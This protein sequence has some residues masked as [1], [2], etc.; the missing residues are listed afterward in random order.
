[1]SSPPNP[2][3]PSL[4]RLS[5]EISSF[6]DPNV[7]AALQSTPAAGNVDLT[8][9]APTAPPATLHARLIAMRAELAGAIS[10]RRKSDARCSAAEVA[11][12]EAQAAAAATDAA[13][14][15]ERVQASAA[16]DA[17]QDH[18]TRLE[19][20]RA[21]LA[22]DSAEKSALVAQLNSAAE[23][24]AEAR[25]PT[26]PGGEAVDGAAF[27]ARLERSNSKCAMLK[28]QLDSTVSRGEK[29]ADHFSA[30]IS[31][32]DE[33][34]ERLQHSL[35]TARRE[36]DSFSAQLATSGDEHGKKDVDLRRDLLSLKAELSSRVADLADTRR[37]RAAADSKVFDLERQARILRT[38][39]NDPRTGTDSSVSPDS[40]AMV[41]LREEAAQMAIWIKAISPSGKDL[42][43][44]I[45]ILK[46]VAAQPP[47]PAVGQGLRQEVDASRERSVAL[48]SSSLK[49]QHQVAEARSKQTIDALAKQLAAAVASSKRIAA[50]RTEFER[51]FS[52]SERLRQYLERKNKHLQLA[53]DEIEEG[54][55][56][57]DFG[58]VG[59][60]LKRV[61]VQLESAIMRESEYKKTM[62]LFEKQLTDQDA[63]IRGLSVELSVAS[64]TKRSSIEQDNSTAIS[65]LRAQLLSA[66]QKIAELEHSCL[67]LESE[68]N[69]ARSQNEEELDYNPE[70]V[71]VLHS[72]AS[73]PVSSHLNPVGGDGVD[74]AD[75]SAKRRRTY[76]SRSVATVDQSLVDEMRTKI[77]DLEQQNKE[78]EKLSKVG[79]R[80][81]EVAKRKIEEVRQACCS[82]FGWTMRINGT[83]YRLSSMYA[84]RQE[85]ELIFGV[86]ENGAMALHSNAY[87]EGIGDEV[88]QFV[89]KWKSIP[90]LLASLTMSNFEKT[91]LAINLSS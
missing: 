29:E 55:E 65:S 1:M 6:R 9:P 69:A 49:K 70:L 78:L 44:G 74:L 57:E 58:E 8:L 24:R 37:A 19:R 53:M 2:S 26:T 42:E 68:R 36:R 27:D 16:A 62:E 31:N 87:I 89:E 23:A 54:M 67:A 41:K 80:T 13:R 32:R 48:A 61:R 88:E 51:K 34:I 22:T 15:A 59:K 56:V 3:I 4:R 45:D 14:H 30:I 35:D 11:A 28:K 63:K 90:G 66:L 77:T 43:S 73:A 33:K 76:E 64:A 71:K 82:L 5:S 39:V 85:D 20:E 72:V 86:A 12:R 25:F 18:I 52:R 75:R 47:S 81:K 40:S 91:T 50:E 7:Q 46:S 60:T 38:R 10:S 17:T 84:E 79:E 83:T 21:M